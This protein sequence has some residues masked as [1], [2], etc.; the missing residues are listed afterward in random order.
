MKR[1]AVL[2]MRKAPPGSVK[3]PTKEQVRKWY[4]DALEEGGASQLMWCHHV[5]NDYDMSLVLHPEDSFEKVTEVIE[6]RGYKIIYVFQM[7]L[8]FE[9]QFNEME[10]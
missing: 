9:D 8:P 2:H 10:E 4:D 5:E 6:E 3:S 7:N 1:T